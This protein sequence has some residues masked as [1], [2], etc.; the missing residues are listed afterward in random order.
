MSSTTEES[1]WNT[2][3]FPKFRHPSVNG[4]IQYTYM[5]PPLLLPSQPLPLREAGHGQAV[6]AVSAPTN[7][8]LPPQ[9][10]LAPVP[11]SHF[12]V[13]SQDGQAPVFPATPVNPALVRVANSDFASRQNL[14]PAWNAAPQSTVAQ[15]ENPPVYETPP[16]R[17]VRGVK[18]GARRARGRRAGGSS[19]TNSAS[20]RKRIKLETLKNAG[21]GPIVNT[22]AEGLG[23]IR[24]R[25][26]G[27]ARR[28]GRPRGSRAG[29]FSSRGTKRKRNEDED[30]NDSDGSEVI[31]PLP[32]Q[33]RSGRR[34]THVTSFSPAVID[35]EA[36]PSPSSSKAVAEIG[37]DIT[38]PRIGVTD[39]K[40]KRAAIKQ[41]EASVCK[42]C[43]RGY[44]PAS[45]MIVFCDGCNGPWHQ[46][47]HDPPISPEAIRIEEREWYC[48][49]CEI[50]R[51][52]RAHL[53]GKVSA[54][55]MSVV[56]PAAERPP[57]PITY[58][59]DPTAPPVEEDESY[60]LYP[61]SEAL[62][63]PK[64]G[65]GIVLPPELEDLSILIDD[66][67]STFSHVWDW[68]RSE[69]Y[70]RYNYNGVR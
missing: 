61:E 16:S 59:V 47:C 35:L 66:D 32:T 10:T 24:G 63:Y 21:V 41:G 69:L 6:F 33:S 13:V 2:P 60:D 54:E 19:R 58:F 31:T 9:R 44:S 45:N 12:G 37:Q 36:K 8:V 67:T 26:R 20:S 5:N 46:F 27:S 25:G 11:T 57:R 68:R 29:A 3:T 14:S 38:R 56:E 70:G 4:P 7:Y 62:L 42:N 34:I 64:A 55:G 52:E 49:D 40:G 1:D 30:K 23:S 65:N 18:S 53:E 48:A 22:P 28:G 39:L 17:P 51:E 43:G 50:L 15:T